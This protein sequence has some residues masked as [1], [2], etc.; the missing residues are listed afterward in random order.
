MLKKEMEVC[1]NYNENFIKMNDVMSG[2]VNNVLKKIII[3][4]YV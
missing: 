2:N 4:V 1:C 3:F